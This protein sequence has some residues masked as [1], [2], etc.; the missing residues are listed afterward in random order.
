M[1][2]VCSQRQHDL[3]GSESVIITKAELKA[4]QSELNSMLKA[5]VDWRVA[6]QPQNAH[7][8]QEAYGNLANIADT[9]I[10]EHEEQA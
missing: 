4:L 2:E 9:W 6:C 8:Y 5:I 1:D 7:L 10:I 3:P